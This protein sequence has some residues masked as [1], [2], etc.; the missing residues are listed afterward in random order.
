MD[1]PRFQA[2]RGPGYGS[3]SVYNMNYRAQRPRGS[4]SPAFGAGPEVGLPIM[5]TGGAVLALA[6]FKGFMAYK[7]IAPLSKGKSPPPWAMWW[8]GTWYVLNAVSYGMAGLGLT[9]VGGVESA[10]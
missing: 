6:A 4:F 1:T 3:A 8:V 7:I 9:A 5:A 10:R 2:R